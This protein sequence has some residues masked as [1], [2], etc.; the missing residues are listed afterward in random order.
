MRGNKVNFSRQ[1]S[2]VPPQY[3]PHFSSKNTNKTLEINSWRNKTLL[4]FAPSI[5][6][7]KTPLRN[8]LTASLLIVYPLSIF[9]IFKHFNAVGNF[10]CR[11]IYRGN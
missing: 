5:Y 3:T 6:L 1:I 7:G 4:I 2:K 10:N 8:S 9:L 11:V